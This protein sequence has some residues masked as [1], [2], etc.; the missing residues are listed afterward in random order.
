MSYSLDKNNVQIMI[1]FFRKNPNSIW[2]YTK[3]FFYD[4]LCFNH[5]LYIY[6]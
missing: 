4:F 2:Q 6:I 5:L 3:F 1:Y